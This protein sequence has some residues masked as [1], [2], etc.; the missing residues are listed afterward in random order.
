MKRLNKL[1]EEAA[2]KAAQRN[3]GDRLLS[4]LVGEAARL[5]AFQ[6]GV[7]A[8]TL[9]KVQP[10][11]TLDPDG[12]PTLSESQGNFLTEYAKQNLLMFGE[13]AS[14]ASG[15]LL[16]HVVGRQATK[17]MARAYART[18]L[19]AAMKSAEELAV[20][21]DTLKPAID[22]LKSEGLKGAMEK[23]TGFTDAMR[24]R[25]NVGWPLEE[26][27]EE[28]I[29]AIYQSVLNL[30]D[31]GVTPWSERVFKSATMPYS[32]WEE[33]LTMTAAFSILPVGGGLM[34][35]ANGHA[36]PSDYLRNKELYRKF[37][38][39][40][41]PAEGETPDGTPLRG[42]ILTTEQFDG[43]AKDLIDVARDENT[44]RLW[45]Q[46]IGRKASHRLG[47]DR[48]PKPGTLAS[49]FGDNLKKIHEDAGAGVTG[50]AAK[51]LAGDRAIRD[52]LAESQLVTL[53]GSK[54]EYDQLR[55]ALDSG[56]VNWDPFYRKNIGGRLTPSLVARNSDKAA[57][58]KLVGSDALDSYLTYTVPAK[59]DL[60]SGK[61]GAPKLQV[62]DSDIVGDDKAMGQ[63]VQ[64]FHTKDKR[65]MAEAL[66]AAISTGRMPKIILTSDIA[67]A[68]EVEYPG[69]NEGDAP[70]KKLQLNKE[71]RA[72]TSKKGDELFLTLSAT[73][74]DL[75][76]DAIETLAHQNGNTNTGL[77]AW[78][79]RVLAAIET[80]RKDKPRSKFDG[81]MDYVQGMLGSR[82]ERFEAFS[83]MSA[84]HIGGAVNGLADGKENALVQSVY[85]ELDSADPAFSALMED[86]LT[87]VVGADARKKMG[88]AVPAAKATTS[89][90]AKRS[91]KAK[92][93]EFK[94][95]LLNKAL[96]DEDQI[97]DTPSD[98]D[99]RG[100]DDVKLTGKAAEFEKKFQ[101]QK[102]AGKKSKKPGK[103]KKSSVTGKRAP[104]TLEDFAKDFK[105]I[106]MD[107]HDENVE[108][109]RVTTV[110]G[111][112][113]FEVGDWVKAPEGVGKVTEVFVTVGNG[114]SVM[115]KI[116]YAA[117][118]ESDGK[119][120]SYT[121]EVLGFVY[122]PKGRAAKS[123]EKPAAKKPEKKASIPKK[124][125]KARTLADFKTDY[126]DV[127]RGAHDANVKRDG[128]EVLDDRTQYKV[129]D[130][131]DATQGVSKLTEVTDSGGGY[132]LYTA[133]VLYPVPPAAEG[134]T[135]TG[136]NEDIGFVYRP[137]SNKKPAKA[138]VKPAPA[139][140]SEPKKAGPTKT[141]VKKAAKAAKAL[142]E[143]KADLKKAQHQQRR[144]KA[145]LASPKELDEVAKS[146]GAA[147]KPY[148]EG[149][150]K[151]AEASVKRMA[152]LD[153]KIAELEKMA[154][155]KEET[156][157][158]VD[159]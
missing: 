151:R 66:A 101:A 73:P 83:K 68:T 156:P 56:L 141:E 74:R 72:Y 93:G 77:D 12:K 142:A 89:E 54:K 90:R 25:F 37:L 67:L 75:I 43:L 116:I 17:F 107:R 147:P 69:K 120:V 114:Q 121:N 61:A 115:L 84:R 150:R 134:D 133:R 102:A 143:A 158:K 52:F 122:R 20:K 136:S 76:E 70:R 19:R 42:R 159:P 92:T 57:V 45:Q 104:K 18:G 63:L 87:Y 80:F 153:A 55:T 50:K 14:E 2:I 29:N 135:F 110:K 108:R 13:I 71:I 105:D 10:Q 126:P 41:T 59:R 94:D 117:T 15:G 4:G 8:E 131:V 34:A 46:V 9:R 38:S 103:G 96:D 24:R 88:K 119:E 21:S 100:M 144:R 23:A 132:Q 146:K 138:K 82:S 85:D 60:K 49:F 33:S 28:W 113:K 58:H 7:M 53:V 32:R 47:F 39:G 128:V 95:A 111:V 98:D 109:D 36:S 51:D 106:D 78:Q 3:M 40:G 118:P 81:A 130:W 31:D 97:P 35:A 16:K 152:A 112:P 11:I 44:R 64:R 1:A 129:G 140:K 124:E 155:P 157:A 148:A 79:G 145:L 154:A 86:A 22:F 48:T 125:K 5:P 62:I 127:D 137:S 149:L 99:D 91:K 26:Y 139:K 6:I 65:G 30:D 123:E 27:G